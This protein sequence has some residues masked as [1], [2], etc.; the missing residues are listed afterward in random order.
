MTSDG[1]EKGYKCRKC[2]HK[3]KSMTKQK[4]LIEREIKL[5]LYIPPA[6]AQRHLVKPL[7]RYDLPSR[8]DFKIIDNWWR[9]YSNR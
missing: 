9:N 4:V 7:I 1:K 3:D 6:Q 2:G 5:G 8:S